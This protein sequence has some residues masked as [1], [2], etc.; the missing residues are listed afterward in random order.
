MILGNMEMKFS[1]NT[2]DM[3]AVVTAV[4]LAWSV[5][6]MNKHCLPLLTNTLISGFINERSPVKLNFK[7]PLV[8]INLN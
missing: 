4:K 2:N 3:E 5:A 1:L 6:S 7:E 8:I